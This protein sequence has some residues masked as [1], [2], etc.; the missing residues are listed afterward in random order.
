[1]RTNNERGSVL[2]IAL[3]ILAVLT[4]IGVISVNIAQVELLCASAHVQHTKA[5][6]NAEAGANLALVVA[7]DR[8]K[9]LKGSNKWGSWIDPDTFTNSTYSIADSLMKFSVSITPKRNSSDKIIL[10]G[11]T[12]NDGKC[13]ENLDTG[14][15]I[16]TIRSIG[17]SSVGTTAVVEILARLPILFNKIPAPLYGTNGIA[18]GTV[19]S[20][21]N[22]IKAGMESYGDEEV[23]ISTAEAYCEDVDVSGIKDVVTNVGSG[24]DPNITADNV[25]QKEICGT[26]KQVSD[27]GPAYPV[28]ATITNLKNSATWITSPLDSSDPTTVKLSGKDIPP[29]GSPT[30][31]GIFY[32]DRNFRIEA[33]TD[34]VVYGILIIEGNAII[35]GGLDVK[36]VVMVKGVSDLNGGGGD[37]V[38][39]AWLGEGL[40]H[41]SGSSKFHYNCATLQPTINKYEQYHMLAW[42]TK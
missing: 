12:N 5:F 25:C 42:M 29:F 32:C 21:G 30:E 22:A 34:I 16:L 27:T 2:V 41:V 28:T 18:K 8:M 20:N 19:D 13:E 9:T 15:P 6:Y 7:K 33:S 36:G 38:S 4:I 14:Y 40:V 26:N 31:P 23:S 1:M 17:T 3:A 24:A 10:W 35:N 11:D 37:V 39:G